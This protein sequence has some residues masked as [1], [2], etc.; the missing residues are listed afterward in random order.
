MKA[1]QASFQ[2]LPWPLW[3]MDQEAHA[4]LLIDQL[5]VLEKNIRS[6]WQEK[7][8]R[9]G[10][11][12]RAWITWKTHVLGSFRQVLDPNLKHDVRDELRLN[13]FISS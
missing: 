3:Q 6:C 5:T 12:R 2:V 1:S 9:H 13:I 11:Q 10:C 7:F 4:K 8:V